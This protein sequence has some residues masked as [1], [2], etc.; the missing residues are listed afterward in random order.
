MPRPLVLAAGSLISTWRTA[1]SLSV[2]DGAS[3]PQGVG[4]LPWP[5]SV[6]SNDSPSSSQEVTG[7]GLACDHPT[8]SRPVAQT[9]VS[10]AR[11]ERGKL[12]SNQDCWAGASAFTSWCHSA[13]DKEKHCCSLVSKSCPTLCDPTN[14]SPPGSSVHG[15]RQARAL[16]WVAFPFSRGSSWPRGLTWV[17]CVD[18][19]LWSHVGSPRKRTSKHKAGT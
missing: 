12:C 3:H 19:L 11:T 10:T 9:E 2:L 17:F 13:V 15:I 1:V 5:R 4:T 8:P 18:S 7:A 14:Y 16:E 6:Q